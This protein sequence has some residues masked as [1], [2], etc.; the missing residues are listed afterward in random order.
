MHCTCGRGD[1]APAIVHEDYCDCSH[2]IHGFLEGGYEM[3][4]ERR[5]PDPGGIFTYEEDD[6]KN[7]EEA[8]EGTNPKPTPTE[9]EH[10][11]DSPK[12]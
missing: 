4:D 5:V 12:E 6:K 9:V 1:E 7:V 8:A 3:T 11:A 10:G 2:W